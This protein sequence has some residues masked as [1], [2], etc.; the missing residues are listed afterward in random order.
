MAED[1]YLIARD[2]GLE[3]YPLEALNAYWEN[4][5]DLDSF[6]ESYIGEF[7]GTV[8]RTAVADWLRNSG[9]IDL[10]CLGGR[11]SYYFDWDKLA[12]DMLTGDL[13]T[14]ESVC[15][16]SWHLFWNI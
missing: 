6:E 8:E 1:I 11:L 4:I 7:K 14:E 10:S 16:F 9:I 15:S 3:H 13:W 2:Y 5:G 12:Q